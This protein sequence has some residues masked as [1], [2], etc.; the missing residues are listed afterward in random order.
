M[1]REFGNEEVDSGGNAF[2][3]EVQVGYGFEV[4]RRLKFQL[5]VESSVWS[6][7]LGLGSLVFGLSRCCLSFPFE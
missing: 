4:G 1:R 5:S 6:W 2:W 3:W 7:V